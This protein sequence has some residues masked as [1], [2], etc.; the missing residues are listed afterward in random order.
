MM[1]DIGF[2]LLALFPF[3][4][5]TTV[6]YG[7]GDIRKSLEIVTLG[8]VTFS[9]GGSM[10]YLSPTFDSAVQRFVAKYNSSLNLKHTYL[11]DRNVS[12]CVELTAQAEFLLAEWYFRQRTNADIYVFLSPG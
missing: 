10:H 7:A 8:Q 4:V 12:N 11:I 2:V 1:L 3:A 9:H 5:H 6:G